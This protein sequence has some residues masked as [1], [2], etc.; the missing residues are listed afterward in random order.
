MELTHD[1]TEASEWEEGRSA[2]PIRFKGGAGPLRAWGWEPSRVQ[3]GSAEAGLEDNGAPTPKP[4][5][6]G[7]H[8]R[9]AFLFVFKSESLHKK[10]L[11][12]G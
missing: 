3:P 11:P 8:T 1:K 9:D 10:H 6:L 7:A 12:S 4:A 5:P 2:G